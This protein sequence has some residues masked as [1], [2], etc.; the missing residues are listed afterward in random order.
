MT[1]AKAMQIAF[2]PSVLLVLFLSSPGW[3]QN[4]LIR[5]TVS[6][7]DEDGLVSAGEPAMVI[8]QVQNLSEMTLDSTLHWRVN[9]MAFEPPKLQPQ[10]V[11]LT[12]GESKRLTCQVSVPVAGFAEVEA[13]LLHRGETFVA[14]VRLGNAPERI[15]SPLTQ[16]EDFDDFWRDALAELSEV[17]PEFEVTPRPERNGTKVDVYEISMR[18]L[19]GARVSGWLEVPRTSGPYPV[20]IRLPGYGQAMQPVDLWDDIMVFSFN[21]RGH[22]R[23]TQDIPGEPQ[24]Y[25]TRGL[26]D[27]QDYFYKGAILDCV[28]AVDYID[29]QDVADRERIAVWGGSQG[30]GLALAVA[31]LDNRITFCAADVPFLCDWVNYF[32]LTSWPEMDAWIEASPQRTWP[33]TLK[34]L[35]YFDVLNLASRIQCR[36]LMSVGLQDQVCPPETSFAAYNRIPAAKSFKLYKDAGHKLGER[37]AEWIGQQLR[38]ELGAADDLVMSDDWP[39]WLGPTRAPIWRATGIMPEFPEGGPPLRWK[40]PLGS[41][42][43]GPAVAGGRVFVMEQIASENAGPNAPQPNANNNADNMPD[44]SISGREQVICFRELDGEVLWKHSY[45]CR[46]PSATRYATGP[47]CTPTVDGEYVYTLGDT[48]QL[49]C[50][51]VRDGQVAWSH[52]LPEKFGVDVPEWGFASHPLVDGELLICMVGGDGTTCVAFDKR[53]G[54]VRWRGLSAQSPGYCPPAIHQLSGERHLVVWHSDAVEGLN[55]QTGE[56]Y[57]SVAFKSTYGMSIGAPQTDG[58]LMY[59]MC[60]N[61]KS[62]LIRIHDDGR[63]ASIEWEGDSER[64][65]DGVLNT[66]ILDNG[67][68]YGCG[69]SGRYSCVALATGKK[70]WSTFAMSKGERNSAWGNVFTI[71]HQDRYFHANDQGDL[72]LAKM[73]PAGFEEISRAHLIE[74]SQDVSGRVLVWS[75]PAFANRSIYL[76]NDNEIRCYS[77]A[78]QWPLP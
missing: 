24:D 46:Y 3:C 52:D 63:G 44:E 7:P 19:G 48:G 76:R 27:K 59:A 60:F 10:A 69:R 77:L 34:T 8:A 25:W 56:V 68:V 45:A 73:S 38:H 51:H 62:A 66:A 9:T 74:P 39:Q 37:H 29:A 20:V 71:R 4:E 6:S 54:E 11:V 1:D 42:Y 28:R 12:P 18:S 65:I 61:R 21:P 31:G 50:L 72:I 33:A 67:Y 5:L 16:E 32:Q 15:T 58:Q 22:G 57:W 47:R 35:S 13:S 70:L 64:G 30:G 43:S 23:S 40:Q 41:G 53:T 36:T 49:L 2:L 55:P 78:E 14:Q 17:D 26:D 75:H